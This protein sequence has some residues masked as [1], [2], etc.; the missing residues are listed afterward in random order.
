M[1]ATTAPPAVAPARR[2][3]LGLRR[4]A[5]TEGGQRERPAAPVGVTA[6]TAA[7]RRPARTPWAALTA[8]VVALVLL[9][10]VLVWTRNRPALASR[11]DRVA[12]AGAASTTLEQLLSYSYGSFD[13]HVAQ[14][15]PQLAE[16][17]KGQYASAAGGSL[18]ALAQQ[19]R[20]VVQARVLSTGVM[21]TTSSTVRVLA[22]V[23]Q[24]TT[25]AAQPDPQID[26][27]RVVATMTRGPGG[28]WLVSD[29]QA[30]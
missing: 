29:L 25:T 14:V 28:R 27:N 6:P 22:F 21:D 9:A 4:A 1:D 8:V 5:S 11:A 13:D 7:V 19:N 24:A 23:N 30:F 12:A 26:Q 16:P 17:F 3:R 15:E 2:P 20:T 18:K 10:T